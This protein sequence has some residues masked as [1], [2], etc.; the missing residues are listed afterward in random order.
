MPIFPLF[1]VVRG[2]ES[3]SYIS[4]VTIATLFVS[5]LISAGTTLLLTAMN[6]SFMH[7]KSG[8]DLF[9]AI[10][11]TRREL[12]T[13]RLL[14][15]AV[16]GVIPMIV[17]S[18]SA[19]VMCSAN[20][21]ESYS[22]GAL[23]LLLMSFLASVIFAV[24]G[25]FFMLFAGRTFEAVASLLIVN[26][27]LPLMAVVVVEQ[28]I[29]NLY[30]LPMST[31]DAE[32]Y[33]GFSP[34]LS[35]GYAAFM[36][37]DSTILEINFIM[38]VSTIIWLILSAIIFVISLIFV[39][40]RKSESAASAFAHKA[41]PIIITAISSVLVA[42]LFGV[43]FTG[44]INYSFTF[45]FFALVGAL[46]AATVLGAVFN[47]NFK[48]ITGN[49]IVGAI[50]GVV[51]SA[52]LIILATGGF[53]YV[54][55]VPSIDNIESATYIVR[56]SS[57]SINS[58][59][60][61]TTFTEREDIES[62]I[63]VQKNVIKNRGINEEERGHTLRVVYKMKNGKLFTRSYDVACHIASNNFA[64]L[65]QKEEKMNNTDFLFGS[66]A[67]VRME[68]T[69]KS[70]DYNDKYERFIISK[71]D[72][73]ALIS[74]A[75]KEHKTTDNE[76]IIQR[77]YLYNVCIEDKGA[78]ILGIEREGNVYETIISI[79]PNSPQTA[80]LLEEI[81]ARSYELKNE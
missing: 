78:E 59:F 14:S 43:I 32:F 74:S 75:I 48:N 35:L 21:Y 1:T 36:V 42:F 69:Y 46:L 18:I 28:M 5:F 63:V 71:E 7:S 41:M 77:V 25:S 20:G 81:K 58:D 37:V 52:F 44:G 65:D 62:L 72:S 70:D 53:G 50:S 39:K 38:P 12:F 45:V 49:I 67:S 47:R 8:S 26:I 4:D 68:I 29:N 11:M 51:Y 15:S 31:F 80:K 54:E 55:R 56:G 16:G 57:Y 23:L 66:E 3:Y 10:P 61:S 19:A 2:D 9:F 24:V 6:F 27:G 30:G 40:K 60:A 13:A 17:P 33:L 22:L 76:A 64:L 73:K 79:N 34:I